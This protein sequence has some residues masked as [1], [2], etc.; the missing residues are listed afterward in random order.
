MLNYCIGGPAFI[1]DDV[2]GLTYTRRT[3]INIQSLSDRSL[4]ES[5]THHSREQSI[6]NNIKPA[7]K[8][9]DLGDQHYAGTYQ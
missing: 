6:L 5:Y 2:Y 7:N 4:V 8:A 9:R 3:G 1:V